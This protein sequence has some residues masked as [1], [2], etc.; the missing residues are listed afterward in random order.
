MPT[1]DLDTLRRQAS[2]RIREDIQEI[3]S[4]FTD[5]AGHADLEKLA[6]EIANDALEAAISGEVPREVFTDQLKT[7]GA[8]YHVMASNAAWETAGKIIHM[9]V[10]TAAQALVSAIL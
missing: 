4:D 1:P 10:K 5:Q 2:R 9:I 8:V 6:E 3:L 7:L